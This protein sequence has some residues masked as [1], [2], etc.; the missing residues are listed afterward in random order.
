[1][2]TL[3]VMALRWPLGR[4]LDLLP[5]TEDPAIFYAKLLL[6]GIILWGM[7]ALLMRPWRSTATPAAEKCGGACL[8]ALLLGAAAQLA[9]SPVTGWWAELTGAELTLLRQ[10]ENEVQWLLAALALC[11]VPALCEEAF[12]RGGLLSGLTETAQKW[13]ALLMTATLFAVMHG[14]LAGLPAHLAVSVLATLCMLRWGRLRVSVFVHLGYN[15]AA[16]VL[17]SLP[18]NLM[19]S[20][21]LGI[22]LLAAALWMTGGI[23]WYSR[24]RMSL[25]DEALYAL[26]LAG[27]AAGYLPE[28]LRL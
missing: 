3:A 22:V 7:P 16:L 21:P 19:S 23:S 13:S 1:M 17:R 12:F 18:V 10:P 11:V 15:G 6:Q 25:A 5:Q 27:A 9:L 8:W 14:S 26:A 24:R 28:L 2:I 4:V 20:V